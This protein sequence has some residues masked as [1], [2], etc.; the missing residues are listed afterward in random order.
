[1]VRV[2][3]DQDARQA[4]RKAEGGDEGA[5]LDIAGGRGVGRSSVGLEVPDLEAR[6]D[7]GF[8]TEPV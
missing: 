3:G 6:F 1:M 7:D 2:L 5:M 8:W 4:E